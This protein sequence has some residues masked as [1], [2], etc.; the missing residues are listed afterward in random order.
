MVDYLGVTRLAHKFLI[1]SRYCVVIG[2]DDPVF[3]SSSWQ[4]NMRN[5]LSSAPSVVGA[6]DIVTNELS[7]KHFASIMLLDG[8]D[9]ASR[10]IDH[11]KRYMTGHYIFH[12]YV[13]AIAIENDANL[14][15][16]SGRLIPI[17]FAYSSDVISVGCESRWGF[18]PADYAPGILWKMHLDA[19]A[20]IS[21]KPLVQSSC[22]KTVRP[23]LSVLFV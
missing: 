8:G 22:S 6:Y 2:A 7:P 19:P 16:S 13:V 12:K 1:H 21:L 20:K 10:F 18:Y 14:V 9:E 3:D 5:L 23:D 4:R 17:E 11:C 15:T